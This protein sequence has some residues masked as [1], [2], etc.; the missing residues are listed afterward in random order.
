VRE[1][2]GGA[3]LK[4]ILLG[5]TLVSP[6]KERENLK[7]RTDRDAKDKKRKKKKTRRGPP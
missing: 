7:K 6:P 2:G 3:G 4:A 1:E 5:L